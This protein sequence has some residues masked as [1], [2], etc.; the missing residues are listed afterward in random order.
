MYRRGDLSATHD[1]NQ[2]NAPDEVQFEGVEFSDGKVAVRWMTAKRSTSVWDS[3]QDMLDIH[4]HPEYESELVW[5]DVVQDAFTAKRIDNDVAIVRGYIN[6]AYY[7]ASTESEA[8]M[9]A[10]AAFE[11][12]LTTMRGHYVCENNMDKRIDDLENALSVADRALQRLSSPTRAFSPSPA[13]AWDWS[14]DE[15]LRARLDYASSHLVQM[16][17]MTTLTPRTMSLDD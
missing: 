10:N 8:N 11:R 5:S 13:S 4:G 7:E 9:D 1:A 3:L 14:F 6:G 15:E 2:V 17:A 12:I 16:R